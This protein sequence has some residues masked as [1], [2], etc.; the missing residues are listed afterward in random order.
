[1]KIVALDIATQTGVA[2]GESGTTPKAW[3]VDL[4]KGLSEGV[5][6]SQILKLTHGLIATHEPDL[7]AVEAAIGGK[8]ASAY[9]IGLVACVRGVSANRGVEC[10]Q[11]HSGSIRKHFLG[12]A[13]TS[14]DFP[15]LKVAH[16]K[17][18]IKQLVIDRC[19]LLKWEAEDDNAADALALWDYTCA[20]K[21]TSYQAAPLGGLFRG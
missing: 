8:N 21:A 11:F 10:E 7:V 1:M 15:H 9:L 5:R 4:G 20:H 13:Y 16:A 18:A 2:V 17:R 12:K 19:A 6:F 3:S 14:R